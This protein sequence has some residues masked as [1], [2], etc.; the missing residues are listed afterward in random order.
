[1]DKADKMKEEFWSL[2]EYGGEYGIADAVRIFSRR[3]GGIGEGFGDG[4]ILCTRR[5]L[6]EEAK[7]LAGYIK[8]VT[9]EES[10]SVLLA[11]GGM[12]D[13]ALVTVACSL[14]GGVLTLSE[15]L[16]ESTPECSIM[17]A[18]HRPTCDSDES[19]PFLALGELNAVILGELA[20]ECDAKNRECDAKIEVDAAKLCVRFLCAASERRIESY[21]EAAAMRTARRYARAEGIL[22]WDVC[23][24][25]LHPCSKEGFFG[26]L[27]APM[28]YAKKW[29]Y[30]GAT[31][32][33]FE[34]MKLCA[35]TKLLCDCRLVRELS[36]EM[37]ALRSAPSAWQRG[38]GSHP[39]RL[40]LDRLFPRTRAALRR[41]KMI[42]VHYPFGG[43][44]SW[45]VTVGELDSECTETL[46]TF[47]VISSSLL[48]V[49]NCAL[50]GFRR[51]GDREGFWRLPSR[52]FA[53]MCNVGVGGIGTV[54]FF[55]D[56]LSESAPNGH[57][58]KAGEFRE[59]FGS[60]YLLVS[61]LRGFST[62]KGVFFVKKRDFS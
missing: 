36:L 45:V 43:R 5:K 46:S 62:R 54:T 35:P 37:K 25:T 23:F 29:F 50:A 53:D 49:D 17:I 13:T 39:I 41:L 18:P 6:Y 7:A 60:Q 56:G 3:G 31:R 8:R 14:F 24:S 44:L 34:E 52:L 10:P 51:S 47:G 32:N 2:I 55:G 61:D 58:F 21:T 9:G 30:C 26:G 33:V 28:L 11:D 12:Y 19:R 59:E 16:P 15:T 48:S 27:L 4:V 1:M 57:T 38:R 22:P 40:K 42:Y 20:S